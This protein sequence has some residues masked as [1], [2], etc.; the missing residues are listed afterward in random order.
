MPDNGRKIKREEMAEKT[1]IANYGNPNLGKTE[2]IIRLYELLKPLDESKVTFYYK[3]AEHNGDLCA[4]IIINNVPVGISS[5]GDL[6]SYQERWLKE[7]IEEGCRIIVV[8]CQHYGDTVKVIENCARANDYRIYWTSNARLFE[9]K[10]NPRV[11]PKGICERFNEH[12]A[13]EIAN[14]IESWCYA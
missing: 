11:A 9:D 8:A 5:P 4:R 12:W 6:D 3:P 7:L 14:L 10:T 1:I 2:S 13:E